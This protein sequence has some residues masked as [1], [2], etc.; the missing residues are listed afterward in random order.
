MEEYQ[1][2][3]VGVVCTTISTAITLFI[4]ERIK[5]NVKNLFDK[6]L[7]DVKK[8]H[9]KEISQFQSELNA[10]KTKENF[11]FTKLHEKRFD[12]LQTTYKYLNEHLKLL[13]YYIEPNKYIED[14]T[15]ANKT[16]F[17]LREDYRNAHNNFQRYFDE[18]SIFFSED[19]VEQLNKYF[20]VS[21]QIYNFNDI[22]SNTFSELAKEFTM[23]IDSFKNPS[24]VPKLL[25]PIKKEIE[26]KF[27]ELL[28]E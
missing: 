9:S 6:K 23:D 26:F 15:F 7:E 12:V 25:Y 4:T 19:V 1:A 24:E 16:E 21:S 17:A 2:L 13:A 10:L 3:I 5:G 11:K 20:S 18:N 8:E 27:R 22:M 14:N 28:G